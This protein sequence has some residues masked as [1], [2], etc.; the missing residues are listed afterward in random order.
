MFYIYVLWSEKLS[1]RYVGY[2]SDIVK[3]V[4]EHNQ[5]SSK[6]TKGGVPW[7]LVRTEEYSSKTEAIKRETFLKTGVGR[8]WLDDNIG[9]GE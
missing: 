9:I 2:T 4:H 8:K 5:G 1:K 6:F 7:K 3:R